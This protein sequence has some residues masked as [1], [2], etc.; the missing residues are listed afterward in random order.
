MAAHL[1]AKEVV[2]TDI[3]SVARQGA[4]HHVLENGFEDLIRV[5]PSLDGQNRAFDLVVANLYL[6]D[7]I[8]NIPS[9]A[10]GVRAGGYCVVS[11][12]TQTHLEDIQNRL[13]QARLLSVR[14]FERSGWSAIVG[15]RAS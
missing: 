13:E 10:D 7:L 15:Y 8:A 12:F 11:G 4:E 9:I 14:T 3:D 1:G 6:P 2:A 5:E